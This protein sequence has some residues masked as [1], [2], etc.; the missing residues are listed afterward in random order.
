MGSD[1]GGI[2]AG[3]VYQNKNNRDTIRDTFL[4]KANY[5]DP[6]LTGHQ[7]TISRVVATESF[8]GSNSGFSRKPNPKPEMIIPDLKYFGLIDN[9]KKKQKVGLFRLNNKDL[10][11]KETDV[12]E[13]FKVISLYNDSVKTTYKK[14]KKTFKKNTNPS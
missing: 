12:Y 6:F 1:N 9:A 14:I 8:Y 13:D 7:K 5:R 10:I 2:S 11:L 4:L 3:K